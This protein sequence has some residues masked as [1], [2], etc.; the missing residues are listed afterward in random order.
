MK[1]NMY[2]IGTLALI[3]WL[4]QGAFQLESPF[5]PESTLKRTPHLTKKSD[6]FVVEN[7]PPSAPLNGIFHILFFLIYPSLFLTCNAF[8][9]LSKICKLQ[10]RFTNTSIIVCVKDNFQ[11]AS[12]ENIGLLH[13]LKYQ[14]GNKYTNMSLPSYIHSNT[15]QYLFD[16]YNS[17]DA[18]IRH[19]QILIIK[20]VIIIRWVWAG[21]IQKDYCQLNELK[22]YQEK[23]SKCPTIRTSVIVGQE[24]SGLC[25]RMFV[26][27]RGIYYFTLILQHL[28]L[29]LLS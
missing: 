19:L 12:T 6:I 18:V 13:L 14:I 2:Y 26:L 22:T 16:V 9:L 7:D 5:E 23:T 4:P 11:C 28:I 10:K 1:Q 24:L 15:L 3:R 17:I 8:L 21:R 20:F 25:K 27:K 29:F